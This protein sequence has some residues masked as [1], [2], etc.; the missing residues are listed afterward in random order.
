MSDKATD[1]AIIGGGFAGVVTAIHM[2]R[3][4]SKQSESSETPALS[5]SIIES[6][7]HI[8]RGIAYSTDNPD[9]IVNG[10]AQLFGVYPDQPAHLTEWLRAHAAEHG[11]TPPEGVEFEN[12]FA[13]RWLYGTYIQDTLRHALRRAGA[14]VR[15]ETVKA[16]A[17]DL[18]PQA[19]GYQ[20]ILQ[21]GRRLQ[22]ARVVLALG[23]F[24]GRS[25]AVLSSA[26]G[27]ALVPERYIDNIWDTTSWQ[28]A[29][30]DQ[31]ILIIG[32]SLTALDAA[33]NAE[34]AGFKGK[35]HALSRRGLLVQPRRQRTAWPDVLDPTQLPT[36]LR[37]LLRATGRAR[38]AIKAAGAD[39]QQLP[40]AI[41]PHLP[42]LWAN[43]SHSD[44]QRFLRHLRPFWEISLHRAGPESAKKL[45]QL[46]DAKRF[47]HHAGRIRSLRATS[48]GRIAVEWQTRG[49]QQ[50]QTLVVDR[51][52]NALGYEF[53]WSRIDDPLVRHLQE[54]KLVQRH[55]TG[56]GIDAVPQTG[57]VL[58]VQGVAQDDLYAVGHPLRGVI[59][60][61]N[62]IG[63]QLL[64]AVN[65][66]Q[67]IVASLQ[68]VET[69]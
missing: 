47:D 4:A 45:S 62:A 59:W 46:I 68:T 11:W 6:S 3:A 58:S 29:R 69:D 37:D 40:P 63:E 22:A 18:N 21:D 35:F 15:L 1:I 48:N 25:N 5:I 38:R 61:S 52:A 50:T 49:Q 2:I 53:D 65:T 41:R 8:G 44:R 13:P 9:H 32:T 10:L 56:F 20:V 57:A 66:A 64:E 17:V 54:R 30:Q 23:L 27:D 24:R 42:A 67:A 43:A 34:R 39:W 31:D 36:T 16:R 28:A 60:E 33:L 55:A 12:A 14:R 26:N 7:E 19:Q 51:V